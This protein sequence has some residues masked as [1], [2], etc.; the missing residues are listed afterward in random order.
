MK[1]LVRIGKILLMFLIVASFVIGGR[2]L[3]QRKKRM[4]EKAPR[5]GVRPQ[6][7]GGRYSENR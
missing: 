4:L 6:M 5:H 2:M 3:L 7:V 1:R